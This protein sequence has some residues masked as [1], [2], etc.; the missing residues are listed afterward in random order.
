[1]KWRRSTETGKGIK[2]SG[3]NPFKSLLFPFLFV[4]AVA[5]AITSFAGYQAHRR[6]LQES[7]FSQAEIHA[8]HIRDILQNHLANRLNGLLT[9]SRNLAVQD[10]IGQELQR[11]RTG[12]HQ[13]SRFNALKQLILNNQDLTLANVT[14]LNKHGEPIFSHGRAPKLAPTDIAITTAFKGDEFSEIIN[15]EKRLV[16]RTAV[17][18]QSEKNILGALILTIDLD[19]FLAEFDRENQT[20][21]LLA[22]ENGVQTRG[23]TAS[24]IVIDLK[25]IAQTLDDGSSRITPDL[26]NKQLLHYMPIQLGNHK[27]VLATKSELAP[28]LHILQQ[29][30]QEALQATLLLLG[31]LLPLGAWSVYRLLRPLNILRRK[32]AGVAERLA[33]ISLDEYHGHEIN[34][35]VQTFDGMASALEEHEAAQQKTEAL[36]QEQQATLELKVKERTRALEQANTLLLGEISERTHAQQKAEE[37]QKFL[38]S[39]IDAMPS[40]LIG[41]DHNGR[42]NQWNLE[43]QKFCGLRFD[44]VNG[45]PLLESLPWLNSIKGKLDQTLSKGIQNKAAHFHWPTGK[46]D[47]L[48]DIVIN[49]I[50]AKQYTGAVIRIDDITE[51]ARLDELLMQ[52]EKMMSVGGLAAGMAH[53]INNPLASIIQNTQVITQRLSP[54]LSKNRD[55]AVKLGVDLELLNSYLNERQIPVMLTSIL[56]SGRRAGEIVN[57]MLSFSR[58]D[59]SARSLQRVTD[60]LDRAVELATKD[61]ALKKN[62]N[63]LQVK[64]KRNYAATLPLTFC[65]AGQLEQVFFNLIQNAAQAISGWKEMPHPAQI[66]LTIRSQDQMLSIEICDNGPGIDSEHQKRIFEPFFTT[67]DVGLGTG[68]GLSVSYFII[69]ENHQGEL[70]VTSAPGKGTCFHI[71]LPVQASPEQ[72]SASP[73]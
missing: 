4:M 31:A 63:I 73:T 18:V 69:A 5:I 42:I 21:L 58:G 71:L 2:G 34:R 47:K 53:E 39:L 72:N 50:S 48:V 25:K 59:G 60:L 23:V 57:N 3:F 54:A 38:T 49:P 16:L 65:A 43:A 68:L 24:S 6:S 22:D 9:H 10:H 7:L 29:K 35:L 36:L 51:R 44:Q 17:P 20:S 55:C 27:I 67:K 15:D 70:S 64:I 19:L 26:H 37:L 13:S 52:T 40:L 62:H 33:G 30:K 1:M 66:E 11:A 14:L 28:I 41:I 32:A 46:G 56:E 8:H 45:H 12:P 61:Y